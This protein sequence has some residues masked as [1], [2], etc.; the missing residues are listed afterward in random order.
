[1]GRPRKYETNADR[2]AAYRERKADPDPWA[3][4]L[5]EIGREWRTLEHARFK[6]HNIAAIDACCA[7]KRPLTPTEIAMI[8]QRTGFEMIGVPEELWPVEWKAVQPPEPK[9]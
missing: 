1:M 9:Q 4:M 2:Q 3:Q 8:Y 7:M 5:R 6:E